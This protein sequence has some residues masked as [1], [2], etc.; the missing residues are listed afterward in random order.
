[1]TTPPPPAPLYHAAADGTRY[2]VYDERFGPEAGRPPYRGTH[3]P[4]PEPR[5]NYRIF[6]TRDGARR[7]YTRRSEDDW[8]DLSAATLERQLR[9]SGYA[10]RERFDPTAHSEG[11]GSPT[12]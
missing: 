1:M 6:L 7:L 11:A 3:H 8:S 2:R 4:P 5:A 12:G 10:A 9:A